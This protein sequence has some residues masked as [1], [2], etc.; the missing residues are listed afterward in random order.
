MPLDTEL[1]FFILLQDYHTVYSQLI[2]VFGVFDVN[3]LGQLVKATSCMTT[4]I[5]NYNISDVDIQSF[6][7]S[8]VTENYGVNVMR[9]CRYFE[10]KIVEKYTDLCHKCMLEYLS[11]KSNVTYKNHVAR[12]LLRHLFMIDNDYLSFYLMTTIGNE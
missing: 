11:D 4:G 3:I 1:L 7:D 2:K 10:S 9:K 12:L 8:L 6:E 5:T